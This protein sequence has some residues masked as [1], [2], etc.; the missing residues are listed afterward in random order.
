MNNI[1]LYRQAAELPDNEETGTTS[2]AAVFGW[3]SGIACVQTTNSDGSVVILDDSHYEIV[4]Q[5]SAREATPE[6]AY[7][8]GKAYAVA[9]AAGRR[10]G[11]HEA[12]SEMRAAL[13]MIDGA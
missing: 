5:L 1:S 10:A 13:G 6:A 9:Y 12:Q 11:R 4:V 2:L 7:A 8:A 3:S